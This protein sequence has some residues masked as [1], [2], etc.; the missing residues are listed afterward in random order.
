MPDG[1]DIVKVSKNNYH[2]FDDM[3]F[4]RINRRKKTDAEHSAP[5]DF[6]AIF[7]ELNNPNLHVFATLDKAS[8]MYVG[9]ISAVYIPKLGIWNGKGHIQIDELW[10]APEYRNRGI[11][12]LLM[13]RAEQLAVDVKAHGLRLYVSPGNEAAIR[14]YEKHGFS[15]S[16][17][18]LFMEKC[19]DS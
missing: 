10:V 11:A 5:V 6:A 7:D 8:S 16:R 4:L 19:F 9:W 14:L 13:D 12:S 2:L 18:A 1:L 3:V 15:G 17:D